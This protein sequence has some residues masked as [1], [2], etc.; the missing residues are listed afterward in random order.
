MP[1]HLQKIEIDA[2]TSLEG[3]ESGHREEYSNT[4]AYPGRLEKCIA[5]G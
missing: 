3:W 4:Q 5:A 1:E 2:G